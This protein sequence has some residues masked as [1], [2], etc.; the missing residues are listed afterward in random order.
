MRENV[1]NPVDAIWLNTEDA[2]NLMVIEALMLLDGPVDLDSFHGVVQRRIVDRYPTFSQRPVASRVRGGMPRWTDS[3]GFAVA[4]HVRTV[5]IDAPGDDEALAAYV[6]SFLSTPL[7]RDRPMWEMH[8]I[9]G[10]ESG[11][12]IFARL[13]HSLADGIALTQLLLKLTDAE[14]HEHTGPGEQEKSIKAPRRSTLQRIRAR[15]S[16]AR[17]RSSVLV[18]FHAVTQILPILAKL[19]LSRNPPTVLAGRA[20]P[21][22]KVVWSTPIPLKPVVDLAHDTGCTVNDVLLAALAG[23][24]QRYQVE[25]A[26]QAVDIPTLVPV[27]LRPMHE[28]LPTALGNRF[29]VVLLSL[30]CALER[31][32]E[33]LAEVKRRMDRIKRGPE[34]LV[35][36]GLL[37]G[38]GRTGLHLSRVLAG[39]FAAKASGVTTNVPGPRE[40]RY[41]AGTLVKGVLGWVPGS[42]DQTL[43]TCIFTYAGR[44]WVG[45][46]VDVVRIPDPETIMSAFVDEM[47]ALFALM[48]EAPSAPAVGA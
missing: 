43:G 34:P 25:H 33:R 11:T 12:A 41:L 3:P 6:G 23:S 22:K 35:T 4:D 17:R 28:P 26:G 27:N 32:A 9:D 7:P 47:H 24:L 16:T 13:H 10:L 38:I 8:L 15:L 48:P 46:K 30:P 45:F 19:L 40:D 1:L 2:E 42:G 31:P 37:H 14:E 36:F 21:L 5:T 18:A 20:G 44:V 29:A 39:F